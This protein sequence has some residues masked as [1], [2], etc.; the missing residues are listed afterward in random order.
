[1][2]RTLQAKL[3]VLAVFLAGMLSGA[4]IANVYEQRVEGDE[5]RVEA[6]DRNRDRERDHNH[7]RFEDYLG[8]TPEQRD[9][10]SEILED[11]RDGYRELRAKTR[12]EYQ[13]IRDAS[14]EKIREML[15]DE[16]RGRYEEW[17]NRERERDTNRRRGRGHGGSR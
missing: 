8:L 11:S 2:T 7:Q 13:A 17:I 6:N 12:P 10:L 5:R 9:Q 14:R 3:L 16:Q 15:T 4:V 1:M